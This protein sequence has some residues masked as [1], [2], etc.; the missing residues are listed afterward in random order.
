LKLM[1]VLFAA[2]L[3]MPVYAA[4]LAGAPWCPAPA[5]PSPE[6]AQ[7]T[8]RAIEWAQGQEATALR[9]GQPLPAALLAVAKDNGVKM[10]QNIRLVVVDEIPLPKEQ[11]LAGAAA[12]LGLASSWAA[13][14]TL[15]YAVIVAKGYEA[16]PRIL[17]HEL[18]HVAQYEACGG[19]PGFL[20]VHLAD[21]LERGYQDSRF[22]IDAR[23][24]ERH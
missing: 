14:L 19:I 16:D 17:S 8:A 4:G 10:P 20:R 18:R 22:E 9:S 13:G 3:A 23:A 15:G 24:H 2:A 12:R 5:E 6:S 11:P 1:P 7:V 21:M